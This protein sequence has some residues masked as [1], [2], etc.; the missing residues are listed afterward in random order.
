[1]NT[2]NWTKKLL[3]IKPLRFA[4]LKEDIH[5]EFSVPTLGLQLLAEEWQNEAK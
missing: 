1:M 5:G 3:V 2:C 4:T